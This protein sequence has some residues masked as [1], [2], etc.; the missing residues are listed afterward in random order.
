M[1]YTIGQ[2]AGLHQVSKKTLRYYKDIGILEPAGM[3]P[4]NGYAIYEDDQ[5]ERMQRIK[6]LRRLRFSLE[7]IRTLLRSEPE[8]WVGPVQAQL[9][10]IQ[11]EGRLLQA[12]EHE[13]LTLQGRIC[14]GK[15]LFKSMAVTTEYKVDT[16]ELN[17]PIHVVG[18]A[19]RVPYGKHEEKQTLINH[20]I[21]TFYG[22][23]EPESIPKR[24]MPAAGFGL[25]C[26]CEKDMSMG[27]YMMGVQVTAL[28]GVPEG[29]RSFTLPAGLYA[30]VTFQAQDREALTDIALE[31]AYDHLYK[32]MTESGYTMADMLAAE[33]Y[34]EDRM[35]VPVNPEMELWQLV[36]HG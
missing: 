25:V 29:M 5:R 11:S 23:D 6:Y 19:T 22:N 32:W 1:G 20:L 13:L 15:D 9:A 4:V 35:E 16:F 12:I 7:E 31:G 14:E 24:A 21:G 3:D 8:S 10:V 34:I 33:V 18:R 26:E 36:K 2:F 28:D 17:E 27:T 30:R